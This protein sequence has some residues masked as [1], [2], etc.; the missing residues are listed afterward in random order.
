MLDQAAAYLDQ[1]QDWPLQTR[2]NHEVLAR[3]PTEIGARTRETSARLEALATGKPEG[4]APSPPPAT[5][6]SSTTRP[7]SPWP[8]L[9]P[10]PPR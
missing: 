4:S 6:R 8:A 10:R 1:P 9:S 7:R 2:C 3:D 5:K